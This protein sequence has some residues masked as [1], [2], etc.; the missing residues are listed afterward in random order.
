MVVWWKRLIRKSKK[1][2]RSVVNMCQF[3]LTFLI[4]DGSCCAIKSRNTCEFLFLYLFARNVY[5]HCY[6]V[7]FALFF[8]SWVLSLKRMADDQDLNIRQ[9]HFSQLS[10]FGPRNVFNLLP[11]T[12]ASIN[13]RKNV[14]NVEIP[15]K[16]YVVQITYFCK[17]CPNNSISPQH[18]YV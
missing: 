18:T 2:I 11:F 5:I 13:T 16:S 8:F 4:I 17:I 3:F 6:F 7:T 1:K 14:N 9:A 12:D 10:L 15:S